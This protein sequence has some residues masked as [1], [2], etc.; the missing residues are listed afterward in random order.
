MPINP[1]AM[2]ANDQAVIQRCLELLSQVEGTADREI[3]AELIQAVVKLSAD[4]PGRGEMRLMLRAFKELRYAFKTFKGYRHRRKVSMFGS[5]RTKPEHPDYV[6]AEHMAR[7]CAEAGF[8]VITGAGPGIMQAGNVGA[9]QAHSFGVAIKLPFEQST[10]KAIAGDDKLIHFR[11]FFSRKLIFVKETHAIALFPG[12]FGTHDEGFEV[13]TL[14]QTGRADPLPIVMIEHAGGSYWKEWDRFVRKELLGNGMISPEDT[15]LY[16][17]TNDAADAVKHITQFY[18][19]YQSLRYVRDDLIL[20]IK[21][22]PTPEELDDLNTKFADILTGGTI[23]ASMTS[24]FEPES[25]FP[26]MACLSL[27]FNRRSLARLRHLIDR[28][29][30]LP[31]LPPLKETAVEAAEVGVNESDRG[32]SEIAEEEGVKIIGP[33]I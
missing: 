27:A 23:T 10:N 11:Y 2:K 32:L 29:N 19:N 14:V 9:G 7:L 26:E 17:I 30:T 21:H 13:L 18:S 15:S 33:E 24:R 31:S 28:L 25:K 12:G 6:L 8:M 20:R 22:A 16:H 3:A 4:D 1:V 5:A